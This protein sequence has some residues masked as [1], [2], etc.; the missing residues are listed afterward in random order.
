MIIYDNLSFLLVDHLILLFKEIATDIDGLEV[1]EK[2]KLN[3][4]SVQSA[5]KDIIAIAYKADLVTS[6][7]TVSNFVTCCTNFLLDLR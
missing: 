2:L 6:C 4:H 1:L 7:E 3:R 5:F